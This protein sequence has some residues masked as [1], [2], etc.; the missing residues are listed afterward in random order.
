MSAGT[1]N[2]VLADAY[3]GLGDYHFVRIFKATVDLLD[4]IDKTFGTY[5]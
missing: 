1:F 3:L 2:Q 4:L 5:G